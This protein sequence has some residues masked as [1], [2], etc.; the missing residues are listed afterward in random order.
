MW[1]FEFLINFDVSKSISRR[2]SRMR[3][4]VQAVK[5]KIKNQE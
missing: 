4:D 2:F 5:Y 1:R 3:G